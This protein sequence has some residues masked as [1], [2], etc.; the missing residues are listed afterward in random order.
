MSHFTDKAWSLLTLLNAKENLCILQIFHWN[1]AYTI[2]I[3]L[4]K[5]EKWNKQTNIEIFVSWKYTYIY[6]GNL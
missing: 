1:I 6:F 5:G 2:E 4:E 3:L